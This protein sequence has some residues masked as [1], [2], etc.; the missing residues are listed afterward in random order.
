MT[1]PNLNPT[2]FSA[3]MI[4]IAT[5]IFIMLLPALI[6]VKRP[7]DAGPRIIENSGIATQINEKP[8]FNMDDEQHFDEKLTQKVAE[9]LNLL[10][11][12]EA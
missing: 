10:N 1:V 7:K 9:I 5:F 12:L 11:N 6:E 4:G 2:E 8:L 3:I